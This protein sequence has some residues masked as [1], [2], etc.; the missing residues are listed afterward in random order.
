[1]MQVADCFKVEDWRKIK[2]SRLH[3]LMGTAGVVALLAVSAV[4]QHEGPG[5]HDMPKAASSSSQVS[6][7]GNASGGNSG[8]GNASQGKP[9]FPVFGAQGESP[10]PG[11]KPDWVG[12]QA[13]S[14][15]GVLMLMTHSVGILTL[16]APQSRVDKAGGDKSGGDV[17][18]SGGGGSGQESSGG[19]ASQRESVIHGKN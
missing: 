15:L 8:G 19:H 10:D 11:I 16:D 12:Q 4:A 1:M 5:G 6:G 7:G 3:A 14:R 18:S 13:A 17:K 2:M 9:S